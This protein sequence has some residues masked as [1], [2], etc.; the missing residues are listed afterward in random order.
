MTREACD[1]AVDAVIQVADP[2]GRLMSDADIAQMAEENKG[3]LYEVGDPRGC[4]QQG[5]S[6]SAR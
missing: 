4:D 3:I 5:V 1:A 6:S 2:Q